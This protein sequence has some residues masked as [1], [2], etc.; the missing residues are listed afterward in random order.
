MRGRG[1]AAINAPEACNCKSNRQQQMEQ[2][3]KPG[4][5]ETKLLARAIKYPS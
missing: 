4:E 5:E 2:V 1:E 3:P